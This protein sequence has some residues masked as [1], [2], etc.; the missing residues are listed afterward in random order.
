MR[1]FGRRL[2]IDGQTDL[3]AGGP[4]GRD[5]RSRVVIG[6][7]VEDDDVTPR[8]GERLHVL[9]RSADHQVAVVRQLRSAVA[10]PR[11]P[12]DPW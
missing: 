3:L 2:G 1:G 4:D 12:R 7:Q 5:H 11:P 6:L 10:P 9:Q 8:L